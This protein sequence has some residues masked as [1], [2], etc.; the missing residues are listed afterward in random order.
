[1][2]VAKQTE[3]EVAGVS[4]SMASKSHRKLEQLKS[5]LQR[6]TRLKMEMQELEADLKLLAHEKP[7][8]ST[9]KVLVDAAQEAEVEEIM[10]GLA[11]LQS[12]LQ[13]LQQKQEFQPFLSDRSLPLTQADRTLA[14]QKELTSKFFHQIQNFKQQTTNG[15]GSQ[16]DSRPALVVSVLFCLDW[17]SLVRWTLRMDVF[18]CMIV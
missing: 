17:V 7:T 14:L 3:Y 9:H 8:F 10:Q 1:M 15:T 4:S 12:N 18:V 6:F 16:S 2:H 11:L 5:P 13:I